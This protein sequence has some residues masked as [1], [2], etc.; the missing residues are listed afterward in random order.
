MLEERRGGVGSARCAMNIDESTLL[1]V[2]GVAEKQFSVTVGLVYKNKTE[3]QLK[4]CF[5]GGFFLH[6]TAAVSALLDIM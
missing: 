2:N 6:T 3:L 4:F 1:V 5:I